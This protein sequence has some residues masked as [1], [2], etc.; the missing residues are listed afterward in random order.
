MVS[1]DHAALEEIGQEE[2][3]SKFPLYQPIDFDFIIGSNQPIVGENE[4]GI[5]EVPVGVLSRYPEEM[6]RRIAAAKTSYLLQLSSVDYTLKRYL[7]DVSYADVGSTRPDTALAEDLIR[8]VETVW[9]S[10]RKLGSREGEPIGT[11]LADVTFSRL[12][13]TFRTLLTLAHRGLL[14]EGCSVARL[15]LEQIAWAVAVFDDE[16]YE[17]VK[18]RRAQTSI[19]DLSRLYLGAGRL[20]GWLSEHSHWAYDAHIKVL[21][22]HK[23]QVATLYA[24]WRH[25][26]V[27]F[28]LTA[29]LVDI[30]ATMLEFAY[31]DRFASFRYVIAESETFKVSPDRPTKGLWTELW[32]LV[33]SDN[34]LDKELKALLAF[35]HNSEQ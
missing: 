21:S 11:M 16:D 13:P 28:A 23:G 20:Y 22:E 19:S 35:A 34:Q 30:F 4:F 14:F 1:S 17:S 33:Q 12:R 3:A 25:K 26:V 31:R 8:E 5:S 7:K 9:A 18:R 15:A 2:L 6:I 32:Q 27:I 29:L 10:V 24:S